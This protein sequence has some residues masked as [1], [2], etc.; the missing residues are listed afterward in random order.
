MLIDHAFAT[1][2]CL[3]CQDRHAIGFDATIAAAFADLVV[4]ENTALRL[5][6]KAAVAAPS[7]TREQSVRMSGPATHG[8]VSLTVRQ[9][10]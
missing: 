9:K 3:P 2:S 5:R 6:Q 7:E 4:D 1:E 8:F 10:S